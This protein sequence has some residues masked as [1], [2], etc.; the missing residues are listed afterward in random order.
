MHSKDLDHCF[1]S[2]L[3]V[4]L[5]SCLEGNIDLQAAIKALYMGAPSNGYHC[6]LL[7][8]LCIAEFS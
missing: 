3:T 1:D 7:M 4:D 8:E 5:T 2:S 6:L